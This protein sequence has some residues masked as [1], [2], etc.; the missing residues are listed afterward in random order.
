LFP[1]NVTWMRQKTLIAC[2]GAVPAAPENACSRGHAAAPQDV[3]EGAPDQES[4]TV[5]PAHLEGAGE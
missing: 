4:A 5:C 2:D 3:L 1:L